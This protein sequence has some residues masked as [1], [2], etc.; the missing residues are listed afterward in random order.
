MQQIWGLVE[1]VLLYGLVWGGGLALGHG[2]AGFGLAFSI[3]L[4]CAIYLNLM[5]LHSICDSQ[6]DAR[7]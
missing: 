1:L 3:N 2:I 6:C 4:I 5:D 7:A